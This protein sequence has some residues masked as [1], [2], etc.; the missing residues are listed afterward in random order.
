M[1]EAGRD[2]WL[3]WA[4]AA[5]LALHGAA[6][7]AG[8]RLPAE[9]G[10]PNGELDEIRVFDAAAPE[11]LSPVELVEWPADET[12]V[13]VEVE[14]G[15][16]VELSAPVVQAPPREESRV[17]ELRPVVAVRPQQQAPARK[18]ESSER[19]LEEE[20]GGAQPAR[21]GRPRPTEGELDRLEM[22]QEP[23]SRPTED[24]NE[25]PAGGGGGGGFVDV[26]S[27]SGA[28]DLPGLA[29]GG[30]PA[31]QVP[32]Q[33]AGVGPGVGPGQGGGSGGGTGGG[34]G[35]GEGTGVGEGSGTGTGVGESGA[36]G[37]GFA[38]RVADRQ[39]PE[40]VSK[41]SLEYPAAA[42][43]DGVEGTVKLKVLVT[44][45]GQVAEVAVAESSGD[46]RLDAAAVEFVRGWRYRPAV[47]DGKARRVYTYARVAF[48]L[49]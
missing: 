22:G 23:S 45:G 32:G 30:T 6:L 13:V 7:A 20:G 15:S 19:E 9:V 43:R 1:R 47:Q 48:E 21:P 17:S 14:L 24:V 28:G 26:G 34:V 12:Q 29:S 41:G 2:R 44:E 35:T 39:E 8:A 18:D 37:P 25:G 27:R 5:A 11:L 4:F 36:G 38:S 49:Q 3:K 42:V 16:V 33:G 31:G 10:P 40:V 46:K